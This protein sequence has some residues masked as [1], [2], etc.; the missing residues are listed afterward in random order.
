MKGFSS[1]LQELSKMANAYI[2]L[3]WYIGTSWNELLQGLKMKSFKIAN[4]L[5]M[6]NAV[7]GFPDFLL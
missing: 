6:E 2:A 5:P 3:C 7:A 4:N 1:N